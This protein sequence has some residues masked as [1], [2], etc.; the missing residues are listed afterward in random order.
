[1]YVLRHIKRT[2]GAIAICGCDMHLV[3]KIFTFSS[4]GSVQELAQVV[5]GALRIF[6]LVASA[7]DGNVRE[8]VRS[9]G[10]MLYA[11]MK[12]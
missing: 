6:E 10:S 4:A 3:L 11:G 1:M 7:L 5:T 9:I 12:T 8:D 2:Q